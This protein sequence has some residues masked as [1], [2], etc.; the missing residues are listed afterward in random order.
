M[1]TYALQDCPDWS[2]AEGED[3]YSTWVEAASSVALDPKG[4]DLAGIIAKLPAGELSHLQ[5]IMRVGKKSA[6]FVC[7]GVPDGQARLAG[8]EAWR[9][10]LRPARYATGSPIDL[11]HEPRPPDAPPSAAPELRRVFEA[12]RSRWEAAT[13]LS[14]SITESCTHPDYFR[15]IGLGPDVVPLI[16]EAVEAGD[17]HW[18]WALTAL[19]GEN[20]AAGAGDLDEVRRAW[21]AWGRNRGLLA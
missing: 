17:Y 21:M 11:V 8:W 14:S 12:L 2:A 18:D 3:A 16:I 19:T 20:P 10:N 9:W 4:P 5:L 15:I 6:G 7:H 1:K 13:E